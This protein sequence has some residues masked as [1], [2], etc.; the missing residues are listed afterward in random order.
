MKGT[1][2]LSTLAAI[3]AV[4]FALAGVAS[5]AKPESTPVLVRFEPEKGTDPI[6]DCGNFEVLTDF[7]VDGSSTLNRGQAPRSTS[8][9]HLGFR[10]RHLGSFAG[11]T[12]NVSNSSIDQ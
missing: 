12:T 11:G 6:A 7:V 4:L 1:I 5:A 2:M 10:P 3:A 8:S 9:S